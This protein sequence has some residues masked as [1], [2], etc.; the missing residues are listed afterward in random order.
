MIFQNDTAGK[1][2]V[3]DI[4]GTR[5]RRTDKELTPDQDALSEP[6]LELIREYVKDL[7]A[8]GNLEFSLM[9]L[10]EDNTLPE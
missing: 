4:D 3:Y 10:V 8:G 2:V 9:A 6:V 7:G 1:R 5:A